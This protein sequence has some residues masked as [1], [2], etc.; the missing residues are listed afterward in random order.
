MPW[1][2]PFKPCPSPD[3][4]IIGAIGEFERKLMLERQAE[5]IV[6]A[7]QEG[8]FTGRQPTAMKKAEAVKT[9]AADGVEKTEIARRLGIGRASVYRILGLD[10]AE[11][12]RRVKK[13]E[14][15]K[16]RRAA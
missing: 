9:L 10:N 5:G 1:L 12:A 2:S 4:T 15:P 6:L 8:R 16:R 7:K 3:L 11:I 13:S 14:A